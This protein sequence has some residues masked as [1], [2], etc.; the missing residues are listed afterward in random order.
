[1]SLSGVAKGEDPSRPSKP[2]KGEDVLDP[3]CNLAHGQS[4]DL[5]QRSCSELVGCAR[6]EKEGEDELSTSRCASS[7]TA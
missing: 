3:A 6:Q 4:L 2:T 1:M 7:V 5:K